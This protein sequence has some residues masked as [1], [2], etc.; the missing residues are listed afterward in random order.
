MYGKDGSWQKGREIVQCSFSAAHEALCHFINE[1][2]RST[3]W[4]SKR[5]REFEF[6]RDDTRL[7]EPTTLNHE[8][9][10]L[11]PAKAHLDPL[12]FKKVDELELSIRSANCLRNDNIICI[13][14]LVQ[15]TEAE[16]LRLP[17]FGRKS[18]NEIKELLAQMGLRLGMEIPGWGA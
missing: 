6:D 18:L 12:F 7:D 15:K 5:C 10:P 1:T 8:N 9:R 11:A 16:M 3:A 14:E 4:Q 13:G 17:N 2:E